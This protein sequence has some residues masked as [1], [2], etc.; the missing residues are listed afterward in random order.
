MQEEFTFYIIYLSS[1]HVRKYY[2][3]DQP[4]VTRLW[5]QIINDFYKEPT[6]I[7]N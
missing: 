6:P 1:E 5:A 3:S 2:E 7:E 4:F